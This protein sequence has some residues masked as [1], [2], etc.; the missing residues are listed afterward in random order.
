M[1]VNSDNY[2]SITVKPLWRSPC[3][4]F[5]W[6]VT[7]V[8]ITGIYTWI[9]FL[10]IY[11]NYPNLFSHMKMRFSVL[12]QFI[13]VEAAFQQKSYSCIIDYVIVAGS[14]VLIVFV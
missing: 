3:N 9:Y 10:Y 2:L 5:Y 12:L 4:F 7:S 8:V 6:E 1:N 13:S 11:L 14:Y